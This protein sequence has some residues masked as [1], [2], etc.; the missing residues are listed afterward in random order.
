VF[1]N[2]YTTFTYVQL[3]QSNSSEE[4]LE[5]KKDFEL[6][7][8]RL[9]VKIRNYHDDNDHFVGNVVVQYS[10]TMGHGLTYCGFQDC[11]NKRSGT[12]QIEPEP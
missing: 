2:N 7:S 5:A 8:E 11:M 3:Q 9:G 12:Y 4:I 1:V 10:K 6:I